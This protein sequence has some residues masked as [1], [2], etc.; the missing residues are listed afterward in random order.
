MTEDDEE[1]LRALHTGGGT[2]LY[3]ALSGVPSY[4]VLAAK[5]Y[6]AETELANGSVHI[7]ITEV[8][9]RALASVS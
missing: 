7:A 3:L 4:A 2:R 6:V 9:R 5:G 8:G 1:L